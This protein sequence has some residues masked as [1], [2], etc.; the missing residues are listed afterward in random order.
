MPK[1]IIISYNFGRVLITKDTSTLFHAAHSDTV[2]QGHAAKVGPCCKYIRMLHRLNR[3]MPF[4]AAGPKNSI[5]K[6][7][8]PLKEAARH[9]MNK[10]FQNGISQFEKKIRQSSPV[11]F[12][13][14]CNLKKACK[15]LFFMWMRSHW[16]HTPS[17]FCHAAKLQCVAFCRT[18]QCGRILIK[19]KKKWKRNFHCLNLRSLSHDFGGRCTPY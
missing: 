18:A 5:C 11:S 12:H 14:F 15:K 4:D 2:R 16:R 1:S 7:S 13:N 10:G 6:L 9:M 3:C 19:K 8:I 17:N